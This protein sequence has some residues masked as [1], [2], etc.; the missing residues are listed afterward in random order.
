M[1]PTVRIQIQSQHHVEIAA[2]IGVDG[3]DSARLILGQIANNEGGDRGFSDA[4]FTG[5]SNSDGHGDL[6]GLQD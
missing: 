2:G 1:S 5:K 4:A 3:Q 6:I